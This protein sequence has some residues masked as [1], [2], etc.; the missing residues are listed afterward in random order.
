M[1]LKDLNQN[2]LQNILFWYESSRHDGETHPVIHEQ[3]TLIKIQA[4]LVYAQEEDELFRRRF[5]R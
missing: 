2:D 1:R 5:H 4:M 3:S